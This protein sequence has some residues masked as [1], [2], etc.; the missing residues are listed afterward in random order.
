MRKTFI[1]RVQHKT[2]S[3]NDVLHEYIMR[4]ATKHRNSIT[5]SLLFDDL[6]QC[7]VIGA[8]PRNTEF[9]IG[10][11]T[12]NILHKTNERTE[13]LPWNESSRR[14]DDVTR[15]TMLFAEFVTISRDHRTIVRI[16]DD[17]DPVI[18][19]APCMHYPSQILTG[20]DDTSCATC[21]EALHKAQ[22]AHLR[23]IAI[24]RL[25]DKNI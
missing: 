7:C 2:I 5:H 23:K 6:L 1:S 13:P 25:H 22:H 18:R 20:D 8:S 14:E 3:S 12:H 15:Q 21:D 17:T 4:K 19:N 9:R 10:V 11:L 16:I 24:G